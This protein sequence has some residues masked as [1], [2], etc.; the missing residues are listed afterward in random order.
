M[1]GKA[2]DDP[3]RQ[4]A[5]AAGPAGERAKAFCFPAI[6]T[7][8]SSPNNLPAIFATC[9]H[10]PSV[11]DDHGRGRQPPLIDTASILILDTERDHIP[12]Q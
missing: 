8:S 10:P 1:A 9:V 6:S 7:S 5:A 4:Q 11:Q 3:V 2:K 12:S